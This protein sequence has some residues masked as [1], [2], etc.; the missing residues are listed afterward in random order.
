MLFRINATES[1][2]LL[3]T[4]DGTF[5]PMLLSA[6][7]CPREESFQ[8]TAFILSHGKPRILAVNELLWLTTHVKEPM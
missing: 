3:T 8:I 4:N 2:R 1:V 5:M 6:V 7:L